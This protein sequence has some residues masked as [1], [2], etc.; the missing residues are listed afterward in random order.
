M[1]RSLS[2]QLN[3][4]RNDRT[5]ESTSTII[6]SVDAHIH[7]AEQNQNSLDQK[8]LGIIAYFMKER[9]NSESVEQ[10]AHIDEVL[11]HLELYTQKAYFSS[12]DP[13]IRV[14]S[15]IFD[16]VISEGM[17]P[18][19]IDF[20]RFHQLFLEKCVQDDAIDLSTISNLLLLAFKALNIKIYRK[21][22]VLEALEQEEDEY[23]DFSSFDFLNME[24]F[25]DEEGFEYT[26]HVITSRRPPLMEC[27]R[28]GGKNIRKATLLELLEAVK[29][30]EKERREQEQRYKKM[31]EK[32]KALK[33]LRKQKKAEVSEAAVKDNIHA[34]IKTLWE[35][36]LGINK[37]EIYFTELLED[38]GDKLTTVRNLF[39]VLFINQE[40]F[41]RLNQKRHFSDILL[42]DI[43]RE[44]KAIIVE[45][46]ENKGLT[47]QMRSGENLPVPAS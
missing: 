7:D 25:D 26:Q 24:L 37:D 23:D 5:E 46:S 45:E 41:L 16:M 28:R 20:A 18:E 12:N 27:V 9:E 34:N 36:I 3:E 42:T 32:R 39:S 11:R 22:L 2:E 35:T 43:R 47:A 8:E 10:T 15:G 38:E 30:A 40:G 21:L 13:Y 29:S 6:Q 33:L 14:V 4:V 19:A 44:Q 1:A 17:E 31:M